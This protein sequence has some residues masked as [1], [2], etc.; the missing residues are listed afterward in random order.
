MKPHEHINIQQHKTNNLQPARKVA[1]LLPVPSWW[2]NYA[3]QN[4]RV[5]S[6]ESTDT[7]NRMNVSKWKEDIHHVSCS[8]G[9]NNWFLLESRDLLFL[10][11]ILRNVS[12][13]HYKVPSAF[14]PCIKKLI[15]GLVWRHILTLWNCKLNF[16]AVKERDPKNFKWAAQ[17]CL[18]PKDFGKNFEIFLQLNMK[19]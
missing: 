7:E 6:Q 14:L 10:P 8:M 5:P 9:N 3:E 15:S 2:N 11:N 1:W 19:C 16:T 17:V 12:F 4:P 18:V 13:C